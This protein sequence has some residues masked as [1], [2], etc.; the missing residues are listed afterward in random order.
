MTI[1]GK[2]QPGDRNG[3]GVLYPL[4]F[5]G[6]DFEAGSGFDLA[7]SSAQIII[8]AEA[9]SEDGKMPGEFPANRR[10]GS[11][12]RRYVHKNISGVYETVLRAAGLDGITEL[13]PRITIDPESFSVVHQLDRRARIRIGIQGDPEYTGERR[14]DTIETIVG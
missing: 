6:G 14:N 9:A 8:E 10:L 3:Y 11:H 7:K 2:P 5:V 12:L 13:D 1:Q 4:R